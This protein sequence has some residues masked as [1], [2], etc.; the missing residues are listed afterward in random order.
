MTLLDQLLEKRGIILSEEKE[1]FLTPSYEH[2]LH[3]S[4]LMKDMERAVVRIFEAIQAKEKIIIYSDYDCDGIP[5]GVILHDLFK[6]ISYEGFENYIPDRHLEGFGLHMN[7]VNE[8]IDKEAKLLITVDLGITDI[9]EVAQ[10]EANGINVIITDHHIPPAELPPAY[11]ILNPK[12]EGDEYPFKELCGAGV[13]FKVAQAFLKK[14]GEFFKVKEGWEKWLLDMAGV[15]TLSD[16][17][18]LLGENRA[19]AYYGLKVLQKNRRLGLQKL[20][21]KNRIDLRHLTEDDIT[22]TLAPRL[23]AASRMASPRLAFELL[24]TEDEKRAEEITEELTQINDERKL[25]VAQVMKEVK[26][27]LSIR[28]E[29]EV[30]VIG[31]PKWRV[32]VLGL[33]ASKIVEEYGKTCFVW[34]KEG[35][36]IIKGSCRSNGS[37]NLV[38]LMQGVEEGVFLDFGGHKE[39]GG[40]SVSHEQIYFLEEKLI[41]TAS[42][43]Q[44]FSLLRPQAG[45]SEQK[46]FGLPAQK[47][48]FRE[49]SQ[50]EHAASGGYDLKMS[51][52]DFNVENYKMIE[53]LAP[54]GVGNPKPLFL[55][56]NVDVSG[57]KKFGK[58]SEHLELE[59]ESRVK[60]ISFF[61]SEKNF[62]RIFETG[63]KINLLANFE[64]STFRN[65]IEL[66]LRIVDIV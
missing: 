22:F 60:A 51:L 7:A 59:I 25:L 66:R 26:K 1:K 42:A 5:G 45:P 64:K 57:I 58:N 6:K 33:V 56:E 20:F 24:S 16:Q 15:A 52:E 3:D 9:K 10:A 47:D 49:L 63:D 38:E 43:N 44:K 41:K 12:Q 18:P 21:S 17:V 11:A 28:E 54:F 34:G 29:R 37:I 55:F 65:K 32:G 13:A 30:I 40:F 14:Y 27:N 31:N 8:F 46:I 23:N 2:D 48:N 53:R 39:A 19:L 36:E 4:F 50:A 35:G 61:K 62:S